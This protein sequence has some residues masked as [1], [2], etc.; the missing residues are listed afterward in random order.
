M[1]MRREE[2]YTAKI[3]QSFFF[4]WS[5]LR[6]KWCFSSL[7]SKYLFV[8]RKPMRIVSLTECRSQL[9]IYQIYGKKL[10]GKKKK[11][12]PKTREREREKISKKYIFVWWRLNHSF[13]SSL[14]DSHKSRFSYEKI[15]NNLKCDFKMQE[16]SHTYSRKIKSII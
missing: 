6:F 15:A 10:E 11:A 9:Q 4:F 12:Q 14:Y 3:S 7:V 8:I 2:K 13:H 5:S 1:N 16:I